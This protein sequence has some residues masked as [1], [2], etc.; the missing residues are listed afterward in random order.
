M[1]NLNETKIDNLKDFDWNKYF[2]HN[3]SHL[4]KLDYSNNKELT[5]E[6]KELITPSIR[7]FQIGEGSE[8]KHLKKVVEKFG[9]KTNDKAYI[10]AMDWFILEENRHSMTLKKYME[11]YDIKPIENNW[12]DN[13]FRFLRKLMG[14]ECEVVVLVTA[15]MIALSYYT[16]LSNAT[17]S[18]LLKDICAQMLHDE[19]RHVVFQS[20]TLHKIGV[21]RNEFINKIVRGIRKFFMRITLN[22]VWVKYKDL[23]RNGNYTK[24]TFRNDCLE[25]L[26]QSIDIEK[27]GKL[28]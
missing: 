11:V 7:A 28:V 10:K 1:V 6:E 14:L 17:G 9:K 5:S 25:Y 4:M 27:A 18:K 12:I 3:N 24:K 20:Y 19:L 22:V 8:G 23:F 13:V 15:E 16:A 26:K 21:R 2:E